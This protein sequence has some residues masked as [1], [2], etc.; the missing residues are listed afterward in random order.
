LLVGQ[1][2]VIRRV[3]GWSLFSLLLLVAV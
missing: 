3:F 2:V 1:F